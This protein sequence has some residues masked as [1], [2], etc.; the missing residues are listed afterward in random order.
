M[1]WILLNRAGLI[2]Y[3]Q[4]AIAFL[5]ILIILA[6]ILLAFYRFALY[7]FHKKR[8]TIPPV[9]INFIRLDLSR[10]LVLGLEFIV[11]ADLIATTTAPDYY[12]LGIVGI[13]VVIRT[14]L[15]FSL[16]REISSLNNQVEPQ[17][18]N[19]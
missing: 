18:Q 15:S 11:A 19:E 16:N 14:I 3:I 7:F 1:D 10:T 2:G 12:S 8:H 9:K 6:G 13:V 4:H 17:P 5:G